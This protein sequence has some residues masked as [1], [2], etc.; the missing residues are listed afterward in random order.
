MMMTLD[1]TIAKAFTLP[2]T[3]NQSRYPIYDEE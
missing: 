1:R 3:R 2:K